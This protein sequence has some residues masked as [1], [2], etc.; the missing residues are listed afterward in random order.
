LRGLG[1]IYADES[2]FRAGIHPG[3]KASRLNRTQARRL[4]DGIRE[5]LLRA[6]EE[7]GSSVSNYVDA[8]GKQGRFQQLHQV[9]RRTGEPCFRCRSRVL[10]VVIGGRSTHFCPR[11]QRRRGKSLQPKGQD[12]KVAQ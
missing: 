8:S 10:R 2:L 9:Y 7:G 5:T 11:C 4:Y 6:I 3:A 12:R 1:N